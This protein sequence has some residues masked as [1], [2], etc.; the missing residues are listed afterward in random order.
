[1][2]SI[3]VYGSRHHN[4]EKVA[5]AIAAGLSRGG[6]AHVLP[7]AQAPVVIPDYVTLL[8]IGGPTEAHGMTKPVA[9][10]IGALSG[11]S[12]Q[13]VAV[14]DTRLR[15]PQWLSGSAAAGMARKLRTAGANDVAGP[16]SFFV[17]GKEP[18]VL[19]PGELERAE[20]WGA[21]LTEREPRKAAPQKK[22]E[23]AMATSGAKTAA[24]DA[25][26]LQHTRC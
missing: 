22:A 24:I 26:V 23:A 17:K 2:K 19:E 25:D 9:E 7:I 16:V 1:M 10:Y 12:G 8:V 15:L 3:V 13:L 11:V 5:Y 4:T 18:A 6:E 14:F 20:A 21:A